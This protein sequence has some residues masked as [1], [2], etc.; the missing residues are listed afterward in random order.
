VQFTKNLVQTYTEDPAVASLV[1]SIVKN[2]QPVR[3][4][5]LLGSSDAVFV[6]AIAQKYK[7]PIVV[8]LH[9]REEA[10][11]FLHDI[12]QLSEQGVMLFP[13]SYKKPYVYTETENANILHRAEVLSQ[14]NRLDAEP[15]YI[16]VTYPEALSEKVINKRSLV[17]HTFHAKV[18]DKLDTEFLEELLLSYD[19]E[20]NDFVYDPGQ[21]S[22]RGGILDIF[23][24]SSDI[25]FRVELFGDEIESIRSFDTET[26]LSN[27]KLSSFSIIPDVQTKLLQEERQSFLHYL[28]SNSTIWIKDYRECL[29]IIDKSFQKVSE[30]FDAIMEVS[31]YTQVS[32]RPESLFV[33]QDLF[34]EKLSE[35][36]LLEFG[37]RF[38]LSTETEVLYQM[39]PQ[40]T[41]KKNF[42]LLSENLLEYLASG[43]Q[44]VILS[45]SPKQLE[46]LTSIFEEI[47]ASLTFTPLINN[48]REGFIDH[49]NKVCVYTDHQIFERHL[50]VKEKDRFSKK[51]ALT[52]KELKT[53]STGDY[54]VHIDYGVARFAGM[55]TVEVNGNKQEVLRLVYKD[56]DLLYLS[57]HSLHKVSKYSGKEGEPPVTSKLGSP[58]WQN[59]RK[60]VKSKVK[61]I[62]R[63]LIQLYAK[64][65]TAPGFAF[66]VDNFL[67]AELES[68]FMYEDTPDQGQATQDVKDDMEQPH[69][70]DRLVC[71][72][73]GFGKTEVAI[74]AA[75]KAVNAGKQVAVLV[76][77]TILA[78][79]HYHTFHNRLKEF[80]V[81][82]DYINRF[83][84]TKQVS[85]TKKDLKDGKIDILIGT[86]RIVNKDLAFKDL[87]LMVIDEEQKFGV[88]VKERLKEM[89][90]NVDALTLTA[91]P[92]PRTLHFSL[93]GA[94]DL[95]II[96]TP[97][98]N[99]RPVTTEICEFSD[100]IIRD[101]VS[102][103]IRRGG[104][105]F[106]VHNR[107][108]DIEN[109]ANVIVRMVPDARIAI[110]HGQMEGP[111]L[112]K[113]MIQFIEGEF[114]VLVSTNIIESGL[115]IPNANTIIINRAHM[116]GLSDVHQMRGRVGR[117][118]TKAYCYLLT[119]P[120]SALT[121]DA[122]KRLFTLQEF[123]DL[124]DGIKVAMRDLD[125]RGAGN[126]LGS[127]Q[128]G[129]IN[130]MGFDMYHKIL[131]EAVSELKENE[132]KELF[133]NELL[134][135]ENLMSIVQDCIIETD[136]EIIIPQDYVT[137]TSERLQLYT[138]LDDID[139]Q[140]KL[141]TFSASIEDRFGKMPREVIELIKS[142]KLKWLGVQLGLEK[143]LMKNGQLKC[144]I[145]ED[146]SEAYF[147][148]PVFGTI[149]NYVQDHSKKVKMKEFKNKL[150]ISVEG[151]ATIDDAASVLSEMIGKNEIVTT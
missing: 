1:A 43:Y 112:E 82:V 34:Q 47:D 117:S 6:S 57:I 36:K 12:K 64:R 90:V 18:G 60:K 73:V 119:P 134:D 4:K 51:K 101:A 56:D 108:S 62:A 133:S 109:I 80:A 25:P 96:A 37:K 141:D 94:R 144:H 66:P 23:S 118:N 3:V 52:I 41:F 93:M 122:R 50:Q 125:I 103:E 132:F 63:D 100:E 145:P 85:A 2:K 120:T 107:I 67:Q 140:E 105:V 130:D 15:D 123:S 77:T 91:T 28:P 24:F 102:H 29:D 128:S 83:K 68:S 8:V 14:I 27:K 131:D 138:Q 58:E 113:I 35:F 61:D 55:D 44:V 88:K 45:D 127:E 129:F 21:F 32:M 126:L 146:R 72:D 38:Y 137:N 104:Q 30:S 16:I 76:P 81:S 46:R 124:G 121:S 40:P 97:P 19:F 149:L 111:K 70:M 59:K 65:K 9:D 87:G 78:M 110:A 71:G 116:F 89:R 79:Q 53:L 42:D 54:V 69:P 142:V 115:D 86:H 5:G 95:S 147:K 135:K 114:D 139:S 31:S 7:G 20:K 22:V 150:I 17:N 106:F 148:S 26:Q 136:L 10:T 48:I 74:R 143:V 151:I 92:I 39:S 11:Y 75:F 98:P 33:T 84:T 13:T 99:R 49:D